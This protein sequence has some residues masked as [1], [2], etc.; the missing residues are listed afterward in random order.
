MVEHQRHMYQH[1]HAGSQ[2][3]Q[4][5]PGQIIGPR[6]LPPLTPGAQARCD[7]NRR[8]LPL[9]FPSAAS[10]KPGSVLANCRLSDDFHGESFHSPGMR[11][12]Q[13]LDDSLISSHALNGNPVVRN[14]DWG[15]GACPS[16]NRIHC[17]LR[18]LKRPSTPSRTPTYSSVLVS[19][20]LAVGHPLTT[21]EMPA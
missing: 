10:S 6:R 3:H 12:T 5:S 21:R 13:A 1:L 7:S 20:P 8:R 17:T 15:F 16:S 14:L 19:I 2:T 18:G 4:T 11:A 9:V